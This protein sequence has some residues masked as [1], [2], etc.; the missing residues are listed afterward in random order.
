MRKMDYMI[1]KNEMNTTEELIEHLS[2]KMDEHQFNTDYDEGIRRGLALAIIN[3]KKFKQKQVI[4]DI[5][6]ADEKD[7]LYNENEE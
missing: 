3:I 2:N 6:K 1:L 7:G 4:I 5:M